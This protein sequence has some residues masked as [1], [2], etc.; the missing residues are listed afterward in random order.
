MNHTYSFNGVVGDT[1]SKYAVLTY[2]DQSLDPIPFNSEFK[3][4][5]QGYED[6]V[7][8]T[9]FRPLFFLYGREESTGMR[10]ISTVLFGVDES[11]EKFKMGRQAFRRIKR[12]RVITGQFEGS[13]KL[14]FPFN[15]KVRTPSFL[16]PG[17]FPFPPKLYLSNS[18]TFHQSCA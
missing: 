9:L 15:T 16:S 11:S 14:K 18:S 12:S 4:F 17:S 8:F 7:N 6:A 13:V 3:V 1:V 2:R 5:Y 10:N